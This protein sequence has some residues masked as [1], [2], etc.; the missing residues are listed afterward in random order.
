MEPMNYLVGKANEARCHHARGF[1]S[2]SLIRTRTAVNRNSKHKISK[3][4][5]AA[6]RWA[7]AY[8]R[9]SEGLFRDS[10][11]RTGSSCNEKDQIEG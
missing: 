10:L 9:G 5:Q 2:T 3:W 8:S 4:L 1:K 7:S 6:G 11:W